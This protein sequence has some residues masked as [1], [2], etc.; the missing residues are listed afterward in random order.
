M[1]PEEIVGLVAMNSP[2]MVFMML[3]IWAI[4]ASPA[5]IN[6]NLTNKPLLHCIKV[7]G[8]RIVFVDDEV[9][10]NF[11]EEVRQ[12]LAASDFREG[13]KGSVDLVVVDAAVEREIASSPGLREPDSVRANAGVNEGN[14]MAVLIYTSGTTGMP[15]AAVGKRKMVFN[16]WCRY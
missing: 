3:G 10:S 11:N 5:L 12:P 4:G 7:S 2:K 14:K 6:Y 8:S 9:I 13:G 15:K 1:A 16:L